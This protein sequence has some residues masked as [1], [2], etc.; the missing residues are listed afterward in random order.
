MIRRL[1]LPTLLLLAADAALAEGPAEQTDA[2]VT[3][4]IDSELFARYVPDSGNRPIV[5]PIIG[6]TGKPMTRAFPMAEGP[7]E[8]NDHPH[9]R[10]PGG[11]YHDHASRQ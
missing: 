4:K 2:G 3:V 10:S 11:V 9:H 6:P 5:W 1:L 7:E 8:R